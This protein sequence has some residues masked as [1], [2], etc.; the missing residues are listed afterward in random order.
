MLQN[1][2][3]C[4]V[5]KYPVFLKCSFTIVTDKRGIDGRLASAQ[6]ALMLQEETIRRNERD[7]KAMQDKISG[8]ERSIVAKESELRQSQVSVLATEKVFLF[9]IDRKQI[10]KLKKV[11]EEEKLKKKT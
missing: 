2:Y 5:L 3:Y 9:S 10:F 4:F 8:L 1:F 7:R 11:P 6:T